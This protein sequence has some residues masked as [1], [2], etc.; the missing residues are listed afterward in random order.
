MKI[1]TKLV[2]K[3]L[4]LNKKRTLITLIGII[5]SCSLIGG[6]A[7]LFSSFQKFFQDLTIETGGNYHLSID[8]INL[9]TI[10][11]FKGEEFFEEIMIQQNKGFY[12]GKSDKVDQVFSLVA[13]DKKMFDNFNIK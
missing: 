13:N 3:T 2:R 9:E 11:N 10:N 5:L 6:V 12:I 8:N 1:L 7:T 4:I